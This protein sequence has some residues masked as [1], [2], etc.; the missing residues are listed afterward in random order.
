MDLQDRNEENSVERK[1]YLMGLEFDFKAELEG[2][3][4]NAKDVLAEREGKRKAAQQAQQATQQSAIEAQKAE[5][6]SNAPVNFESQNDNTN[7]TDLG[8][9]DPS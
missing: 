8:I 6:G 1:E 4:I 7:A 2:L 5:T 9:F 3:M